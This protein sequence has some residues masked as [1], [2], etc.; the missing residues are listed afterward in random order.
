MVGVPLR[1]A[2]CVEQSRQ[3]ASSPLR[4]IVKCGRRNDGRSSNPASTTPLIVGR[5]TIRYDA[6]R[7]SSALSDPR[8]Q[9]RRARRRPR[10]PTAR[11]REG[12]RVVRAARVVAEALD[13]TRAA[14]SPRSRRRRLRVHRGAAGAVLVAMALG[15][16]IRGS[17]LEGEQASATALAAEQ[18]IDAAMASSR[19]AVACW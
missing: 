6:N 14:P 10:R 7:R 11:P 5:C 17:V 8:P 16:R 19:S 9:R 15:S 13:R 3:V 4:R 1:R 18:A 2:E 12:V